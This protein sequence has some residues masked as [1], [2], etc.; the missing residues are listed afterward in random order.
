MTAAVDKARRIAEQA[1]QGQVKKTGGLVIDHVSRV[2][3][4]VSG[5]TETTVAWLHD[6][7]E[8]AP[9]WNLARL[10]DE[11][12]DE[13]VIA[14]VDALTKRPGEDHADLVRRGAQNTLAKTVKRADLTDNLAEAVRV[15][16][17]GSKY[18]TGL[19]ILDGEPDA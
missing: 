7:L 9:D 14:A 16:R 6:V 18:R 5:D 3:G 15:G 12:F 10:H 1:L 2:A 17:D 13:E 8:R 19:E 4:A 11:G